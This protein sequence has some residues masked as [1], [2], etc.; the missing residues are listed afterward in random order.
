MDFAAARL[1]M[2]ECQVRPNRVTEPRLLD[3][4][5]AI[6]REPFVPPA[7]RDL[8]YLDD[9]IPLPG[10]RA[11]MNPQVFARLLQEAGIRPLEVVLDL[12]CATGYSAAVL[13]RLA[14]TVVALESDP[15]LAAEA[16]ARLA[17]L[18][19]DNVAVITGP[20]E[21]GDPGHGPYDVIVAEGRLARLPEALWR[22][23]APGG[24]LVAV[25]EGAGPGRA[26]LF[27]RIG[28][29]LSHQVIFDAYAAPLPGFAQPAGFVF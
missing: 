28:N 15:A 8:A 11:L 2:V 14:T 6:P 26:T 22:Q 5:A 23:L 25:M 10:H 19:I 9:E 18:G 13:S 27:Q 24:R 16:Q 20:L 7:L 1:N 3:A 12:G 4:L 29:T 21:A 17:E